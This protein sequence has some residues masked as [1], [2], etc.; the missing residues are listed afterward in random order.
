MWGGGAW[1]QDLGEQSRGWRGS[2]H[3]RASKGL[4]GGDREAIGG[5]VPL[6]WRQRV[7]AAE[8]L[9]SGSFSRELT[10]RGSAAGA[11][12]SMKALRV[13]PTAGQMHPDPA[14]GLQDAG[15]HFEQ[16]RTQAA[17]LQAAQGLGQLLAEQVH[18][19]VSQAVQHQ[20]KGIGEE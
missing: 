3:S 20:A 14:S 9:G 17:D 13:G 10:E 12:G 4:E 2:N 7:L 11:G 15:S 16:A 18:Q 8:F 5:A 1:V 6:G 19:V